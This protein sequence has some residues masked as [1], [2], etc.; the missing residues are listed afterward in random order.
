MSWLVCTP[1]IGF[2]SLQKDESL[3]ENE[4][5]KQN[6][7]LG[8]VWQPLVT[9]LIT[10]PPLSPWGSQEVLWSGCGYRK[11]G[12]LPLLLEHLLGSLLSEAREHAVL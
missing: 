6:D 10:R 7:C 11:S 3:R 9:F 4:G 2:C 1:R 12:P 8:L 5:R